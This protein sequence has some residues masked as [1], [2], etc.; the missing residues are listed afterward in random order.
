[1]IGKFQFEA[2]SAT[3][4]LRFLWKHTF[5]CKGRDVMY[6]YC[7]L[8]INH[9]NKPIANKIMN[10]VRWS[11]RHFDRSGFLHYFTAIYLSVFNNK[12]DKTRYIFAL[13][14][15]SSNICI[16]NNISKAYIDMI[17]YI[18]TVHV[19]NVWFNKIE[20][21]VGHRNCPQQLKMRPCL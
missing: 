7:M 9:N 8:P 19:E 2:S 15:I 18:Y 6:I 20:F 14:A 13:N 10:Y 16:Y 12:R 1:M 11:W 17:L 5:L 3:N 21:S 4:E